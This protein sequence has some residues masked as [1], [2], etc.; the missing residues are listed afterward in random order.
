MRE[1]LRDEHAS[2]HAA[3]QR[4]DFVFA[5][6]PKRQFFEHLF[7]V[8]RIRAFAE[9]TAAERD[10][11]PNRFEHVGREL[12]RHEADLRAGAA[13]IFDDVVTVGDDRSGGEIHGSAHDADQ[14]GFSRSVRS[15]QREDFAALDLEV[16]VLQRLMTRRVSL[17]QLLD[18]DDRLHVRPSYRIEGAPTRIRARTC[19]QPRDAISCAHVAGV[20]FDLRRRIFRERLSSIVIEQRRERPSS[21]DIG[22]ELRDVLGIRAFS[23][24]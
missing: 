12:L 24:K 20:D 4:H 21:I 15:E 11:V 14:R 13:K 18:R 19:R 10:G 5:F 17:R 8:L 22:R 2:F 3:R 16:D 6:V 9:Q 7:D 1:R 23:G